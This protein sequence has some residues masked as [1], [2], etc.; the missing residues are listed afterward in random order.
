MSCYRRT[1]WLG[2]VLIAGFRI[3]SR[4]VEVKLSKLRHFLCV[5][6]VSG[7]VG[8]HASY[9]GYLN[10]GL[11]FKAFFVAPGRTNLLSTNLN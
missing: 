9:W 5:C 3:I 8:V 2:P 1:I 7:H 4:E 6:F 11:A 10:S